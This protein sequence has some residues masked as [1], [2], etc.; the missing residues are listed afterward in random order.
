LI[1][2]VEFSEPI[3]N[4]S[5]RHVSGFWLP[6]KVLPSS[7]WLLIGFQDRILTA[8]CLQDAMFMPYGRD[9]QSER[10]HQLFRRFDGFHAMLC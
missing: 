2:A 5:T 3:C 4:A 6:S 8:E 10:L 7:N 9:R 1:W